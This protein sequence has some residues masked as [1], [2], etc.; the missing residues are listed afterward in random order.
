MRVSKY[1]TGKYII[2]RFMNCA[3]GLSR[4]VSCIT[5]VDFCFV[6]YGKNY[7]PHWAIFG[8]SPLIDHWEKHFCASILPV[9]VPVVIIH[10]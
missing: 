3:S 9:W 10:P 7:E 5:H 8:C 1:M 4:P 2:E 6:A